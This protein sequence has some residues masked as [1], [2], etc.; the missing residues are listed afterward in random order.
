MQRFKRKI[1]EFGVT[2][3][4]TVNAE[5]AADAENFTTGTLCS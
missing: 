1:Y 3:H 4:V 5:I 2:E